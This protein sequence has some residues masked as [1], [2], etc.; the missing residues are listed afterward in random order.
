MQVKL[1]FLRWE[2]KK[3]DIALFTYFI[4]GYKED[5]EVPNYNFYREYTVE[6]EEDMT[7]DKIF[8]YFNHDDRPNGQTERSMCVGD[9]IELP[10]GKIYGVNP[11]GFAELRKPYAR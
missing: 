4:M 8:V 5:Q 6:L 7:L 9:L 2:D 11:F 10:N 1:Y 3:Q